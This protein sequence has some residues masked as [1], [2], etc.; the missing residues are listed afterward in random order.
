[1]RQFVLKSHY[2]TNALNEHNEAIKNTVKPFDEWS[3]V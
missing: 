2:G 1:M 3:L